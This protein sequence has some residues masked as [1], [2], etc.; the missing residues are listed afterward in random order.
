MC[1]TGEGLAAEALEE[2]REEVVRG[3]AGAEAMLQLPQS[4]AVLPFIVLEHSATLPNQAASW[5]ATLKVHPVLASALSGICKL[6]GPPTYS[7]LA[8]LGG[9]CKRNRN[10]CPL[11]LSGNRL[12]QGVVA[13][14]H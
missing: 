6:T 8:N 11:A 4:R 9:G 14:S 12:K 13:T 2:V 7:H 5:Q 10:L 1:G 3:C